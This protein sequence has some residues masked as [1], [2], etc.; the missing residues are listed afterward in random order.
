LTVKGTT[1]QIDSTQVNIGENIIELNY[2]GSQTTSGII[3]KDAT[4]ASTTSGSLLWDATTDYWKAG[5][6]GSEAKVL[7][8]GLGVISGSGQLGNYET[9]G[10]GDRKSVV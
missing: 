8:D 5:K 10:R 4:G 1:T 6:L 2:G 7:T 9:T 3:T